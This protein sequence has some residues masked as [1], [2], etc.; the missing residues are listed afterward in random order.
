MWDTT[1]TELAKDGK[2]TSFM[3]VTVLRLAAVNYIKLI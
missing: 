1:E 2:S 3:A